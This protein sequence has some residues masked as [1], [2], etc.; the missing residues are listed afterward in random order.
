MNYN[1]IRKCVV[2][3]LAL[4]IGHAEAAPDGEAKGQGAAI[5]NPYPESAPIHASYAKF[6]MRMTSDPTIRAFAAKATREDAFR[7][8][9][10]LSFSGLKRLDDASLET[11]LRI[12]STILNDASETECEAILQGPS[13]TLGPSAM[14]KGLVKL[15]QA[16]ADFWFALAGNAA[17]AELRQDPIPSVK[18]EDV[19]EAVSRIK[20]TLPSQ[21]VL[22]FASAQQN[23]RAASPSN[24]C[25]AMRIL[26]REGAAIAEPYRAAVARVTVP[27]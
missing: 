9:T 17:L 12:V 11:R 6:I 7:G 27:H 20:A 2:L 1:R 4:A 18:Q 25:W 26:Y 3:I 19:N 8:A 10:S 16:D 13:S 23:L 21:E 5:Y 22:T 24:A 15:N 14:D